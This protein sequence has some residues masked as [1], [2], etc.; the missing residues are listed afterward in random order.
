MLQGSVE[1]KPASFEGSAN[2]RPLD[3]D[4]MRKLVDSPAFKQEGFRGLDVPS[5]RV[6]MANVLRAIHDQKVRDIIVKSVPVSVVDDL[7]RLERTPEMA[8]HDE[9]VLG[10]K[11]ASDLK[12]SIPLITDS[13]NSAMSHVASAIAEM[14]PVLFD[15]EGDLVNR[16]TAS[17]TSGEHEQNIAD[18][19]KEGEE[20]SEVLSLPTGEA[21]AVPAERPAGEP[22]RPVSAEAEGTL[23]PPRKERPN[24][25]IGRAH[26]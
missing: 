2:V 24:E 8:L 21:A 26:V 23:L 13:T 25:Q 1:R 9:S 4:V 5:Q 17:S 14:S 20:K 12:L 6:M 10:N 18:L 7:V 15:S 22:A 3:F 19:R 16:G 11:E